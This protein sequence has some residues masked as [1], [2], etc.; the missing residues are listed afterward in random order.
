V[1]V[2]IDEARGEAGN[3]WGIKFATMF[4]MA[5]DSHLFRTREELAQEGWELQGNAFVRG[6]ERFLPLYEAKLI[7]HYDHRWA[8]YENGATRAVSGE[9]KADP[10]TVVLPRYWVP[11]A[12]VAARLQGK[13][14]RPWLL[15]W[16]DIARST[17]ERTVIAGVVPRVGVGNKFPLIFCSQ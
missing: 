6:Q 16:R 13:W 7:H 11:E 3:P 17:D 15:G 9:A 5:N 8:T 1:P 2:L 4:H 12:E 14:D 10:D